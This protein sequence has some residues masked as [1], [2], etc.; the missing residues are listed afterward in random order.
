MDVF[1]SWSGKRSGAAAE[2]LRD[3]LPQLI[4]ALRPWLSS[5]DI[6]K[7]TRWRTELASGLEK[8]KA[9]I[10]CLTPKNLHSD[11]ILFEA[12]ALSKSVESAY[13]CPFLIDLN[14]SDVTSP[15]ADFQA[16]QPTHDDVFKLL[17]TLNRACGEAGRSEKQLEDA[18]E[19]WW[20]RLR[21]GLEGLPSDEGVAKIRRPEGDIL[22]EI[23]EIVRTQSR[24]ATQLTDYEFELQEEPSYVWGTTGFTFPAA[25]SLLP[26]GGRRFKLVPR[27]WSSAVRN[28]VM[29]SLAGRPTPSSPATD[30]VLKSIGLDGEAPSEP[31]G[32]SSK[33]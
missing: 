6:E 18:F 20:P 8:S 15:L 25:G 21:T 24:A 4:N 30:A 31:E 16:T 5:S 27:V 11:W 33:K 23:L 1:I 22:E 3:W 29:E 14:N 2:V 10:I 26:E 9:G 19:M 12:G 28:A 7:G 13:V 32:P 17:K